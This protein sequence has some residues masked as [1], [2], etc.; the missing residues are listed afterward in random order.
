MRLV[1]ISSLGEVLAGHGCGGGRGRRGLCPRQ[2]RKEKGDGWGPGV[3]GGGYVR[4]VHA[5]MV[6][7]GGRVCARG[8]RRKKGR[9]SRVWSSLGFEVKE[10]GKGLFI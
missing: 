9:I 4:W 3:G 7:G 1:F 2:R 6:T 10:K 5:W 8:D